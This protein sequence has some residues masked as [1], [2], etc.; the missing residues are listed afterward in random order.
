MADCACL[1]GGWDDYDGS[2]FQSS[3]TRTARKPHACKECRRPIRPGERYEHFSTKYEDRIFT[4]KTCATCAEIR[5]ALYCDG[6][7]FGRMWEDIREQFFE[8]GGL[9]I[10]CVDKLSTVA[11]KEVLT[12]RWREFLGVA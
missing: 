7:V 4:I 2:G 9:N 11:A 10:A 5:E 12:R 6:Y 8:Q 3:T 1:Y